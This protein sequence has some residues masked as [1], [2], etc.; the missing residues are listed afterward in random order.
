MVMVPSSVVLVTSTI[1]VAPVALGGSLEHF[2]L[3]VGCHPVL[4]VGRVRAS[5]ETESLPAP[6]KMSSPLPSAAKMRS[7]PAPPLARSFASPKRLRQSSPP[8]PERSFVPNPPSESRC[9]CRR[10]DRRCPRRRARTEF[11]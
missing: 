7:L 5:T 10:R 3:A 9:L 1:G 6:Q 8:L 4:W 11:L 2:I